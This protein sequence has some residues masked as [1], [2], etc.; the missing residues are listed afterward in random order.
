[1]CFVRDVLAGAVWCVFDG[2]CLCVF[3]VKVCVFFVVDGGAV[4]FV[5][6]VILCLCVLFSYLFAWSVCDVLCDVVWYVVCNV[7]VLAWVIFV[8]LC[9]CGL[10]ALLNVVE[11]FVFECLCLCG[12]RV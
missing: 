11:W 3:C 9:L 1:M 10:C 5:V 12:L 2:L 6:C 4:S 8:Q 7:F